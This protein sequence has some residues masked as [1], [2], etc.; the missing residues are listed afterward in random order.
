MNHRRPVTDW[1]T[2][3]DHMDPQWTQDPYKIW[4]EIRQADCPIAHTE[5]YGG[6]YL[7][8]TFA[9]MREITNDTAHF[10]SRQVVVREAQPLVAGGAPPITSD[11]PR[12]RLARMVLMPPFAPHAVKKLIPMTRA[13]CDDLIDNFA[14]RGHCDGAV[15]YA[16]HIPVHLIAHM[17]GVPEDDADQFRA[18]INLILVDGITDDLSMNRGLL[19]ITGYFADHLAARRR[20]P[21]EDLI[22]YLAQQTY[23]DGEPFKDNH[24][25]G[26]LRL[27]LIA[28]IDTTWSAIGTTIWHLAQHPGQRR[29]LI[30]E[31]ALMR[32]AVEEFL[33][34]YA[35]VTMA[36]LIVQDTEINGCPMKAGEMLMLPFPA[37]N[38]D[39]AMFERPDDVILD[40]EDA[41]RHAAFGMGIH[42]CIGMHLARMELTVAITRLLER[43]PDFRL[44][45]ETT[46]SRGAIRGPRSLPLAF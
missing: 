40:R 30:G 42:R 46:W 9:D 17:L 2:D 15:E 33:R 25:L 1:M 19:E 4:S 37:A 39:P 10:S 38:R 16:Q 28:G 24:I 22:S 44:A 34:A 45:G 12:H 5:R 14:D 6:V 23:E 41:H 29:R 20:D 32:Q 3:W 26:S 8:T 36:R 7:P 35:P 13:L 27:V 43:I 18:W 21:G 31:P 11:P